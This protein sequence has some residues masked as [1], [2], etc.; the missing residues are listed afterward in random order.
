MS[1]TA[2]ATVDS[3]RLEMISEMPIKYPF[4]TEEQDKISSLLFQIDHLITLHQRKSSTPNSIIR[5][6]KKCQLFS[7][8]LLLL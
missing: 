4:N 7:R 5:K 8:H 3:V 2:K 6:T 1:M